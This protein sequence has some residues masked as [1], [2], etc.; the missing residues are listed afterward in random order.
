M[1]DH[2]Q[3]LFARVR[4]FIASLTRPPEFVCGDCERVMHC[5]LPPHKDCVVR[6]AQIARDPDGLN[7]RAKRRAARN[8]L[9]V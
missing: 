4:N 8:L 1:L 7:L 5:G 2:I 6:A 9:E 3:T